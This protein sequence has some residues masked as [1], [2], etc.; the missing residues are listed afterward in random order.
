MD[1]NSR[2]RGAAQLVEILNI[3]ASVA[4]RL[5]HRYGR[6][7][8]AVDKYMAHPERWV[9]AP[10]P[11]SPRTI[12]ETVPATRDNPSELSS[13]YFSITSLSARLFLPL[14]PPVSTA[15]LAS[16]LSLKNIEK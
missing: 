6:V 2:G 8:T 10:K 12:D 15:V 3:S 1:G 14:F 5:L 13:Y 9:E 4:A 16:L 11:P 7:E